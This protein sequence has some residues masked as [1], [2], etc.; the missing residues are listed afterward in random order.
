MNE[1]RA[2]MALDVQQQVFA[3]CSE[4]EEV[5]KESLEGAKLA[6]KTQEWI[7]S[8]TDYAG[9]I[10]DAPNDILSF[11]EEAV[12]ERNKM[13]EELEFVIKKLE[14]QLAKIPDVRN[15]MVE[16]YENIA[17]MDIALNGVLKLNAT[18]DKYG[19]LRKK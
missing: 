5:V 15:W 2:D 12:N 17:D 4:Y 3:K 7:N 6:L 1:I 18:F 19:E 14:Y 8:H 13:C 11:V 10:K 9:I 16:H